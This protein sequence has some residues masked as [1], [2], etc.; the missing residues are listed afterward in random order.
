[1]IEAEPTSD[2]EEHKKQGRVRSHVNFG[3]GRA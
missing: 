2:K 3:Q 1:M